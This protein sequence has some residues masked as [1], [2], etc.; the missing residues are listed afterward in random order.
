M[1][2]QH[3]PSDAEIV[4]LYF[5]RD[6]E[7]IRK[8]ADKYGGYCKSISMSLLHSEPDADECVNDTWLKTWNSIPPKR[9]S[10]LRTFLARIVRALSIDRYRRYHSEKYNRDLEVALDELTVCSPIEEGTTALGEEL[11]EFVD[12]LEEIDRKLFVGRYWYGYPVH[13]LAEAY[14]MT[15]NA[16]SLRLYRVRL[17]LRAHLEERGYRI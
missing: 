8:T 1:N 9:P 12:G 6:E 4:E 13:R 2:H 14:G 3:H 11:R 15:P 16:V 17:D 10:V 7:A 5:A